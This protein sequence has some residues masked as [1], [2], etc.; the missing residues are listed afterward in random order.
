MLT[1]ICT[2]CGKEFPL[3]KDFFFKNKGGKDGFESQC[4]ACVKERRHKRYKNIIYEIYC[5]PTDK[6]Y[7]GQ[8]IKPISERISK[9]FSD[10]KRG[11]P[12]PLYIDMRKYDK[13]EFEYKILEEVHDKN[14]LDDR[15]RYYISLY[16]NN[17][18]VLYNR[19]L[20]GRKNI[21]VLDETKHLQAK[22]RGTK[23]FIVFDYDG[24]EL[25][26]FKSITDARNYFGIYYE[27]GQLIDNIK[28]NTR[29]Y[30]VISK[31]NFTIDN[32]IK[33]IKEYRMLE[34]LYR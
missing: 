28:L 7:I 4:K 1:K 33:S 15:E 31:E 21:T 19:E 3:T 29:D 11:R 18:K 10:A 27:F 22:S 5:K 9:H 20:G 12:Q 26:Q 30:I 6:Y 16:I 13:N 25:G 14:K 17:G 34:Y 2:K 24:N 8:T 32:L 23:E